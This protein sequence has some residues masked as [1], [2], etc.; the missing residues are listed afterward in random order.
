MSKLKLVRKD[1]NRAMKVL[2]LSCICIISSIIISTKKREI[3]ILAFSLV[4]ELNI[5]NPHF[6]STALSGTPSQKLLRT[7]T[8]LIKLPHNAFAEL[9]SPRYSGIRVIYVQ[10]PY[11]TINSINK[12]RSESLDSGYLVSPKFKKASIFDKSGKEYKGKVRLKGDLPDHWI[13]QKRYSLRVKL[14]PRNINNTFPYRSF[15]L[16]KLRSRQYPYEFLFSDVLSK[17]GLPYTQHEVVR[18]FVN[19]DDWGYMDLQEHYGD[20]LLERQKRKPSLIIQLGDERKWKY[21]ISQGS[22]PRDTNKRYWLSN[23]RLYVSLTGKNSS[24]LLPHEL[25]QLD[26]VR[27]RLRSPDYQSILFDLEKLSLGNTLFDLWG[28]HHPAVMWNHRYYLNPYTL[29]LE[30]IFQDQGEFKILGVAH[31][32]YRTSFGFFSPKTIESLRS[33][34][35]HHLNHVYQVL[36]SLIIAYKTSLFRDGESLTSKIIDG[37]HLRI[38]KR[39]LDEHSKGSYDVYTSKIYCINDSIPSISESLPA[40]PSIFAHQLPNELHLFNL[41]CSNIYLESITSCNQEYSLNRSMKGYVD[42]SK[43]LILPIP[44]SEKCSQKPIIRYRKPNYTL[45]ALSVEI[46]KSRDL[47]NPLTTTSL[48]YWVKS[49]GS[50]HII[51]KGTYYVES[52]IVLSSSLYIE[53]GTTLIF[54][55]NS[56]LIVSGDLTVGA[57]GGQQVYMRSHVSSRGWLGMYVYSDVSKPVKVNVNNLTILETKALSVGVLNLTGGFNVYNADVRMNHVTVTAS[58]AEDALNIVHSN[59][60][61]EDLNISRAYSDAFDCDY[62]TGSIHNLRLSSVGGDGL[63]LSGSKITA[64]VSSALDVKDKVISV[65][66]KTRARLYLDSINRAYTA[67]AVKDAS[68]SNI[69]L[70]NTNTYGPLVMSYAKKYIYEG[71]A[72]ANVSAS[73]GTSLSPGKYLSSYGATIT[74]NGRKV[75]P[76]KLNVR[77]LYRVGPMRKGD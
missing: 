51:K 58:Q 62:C 14:D 71:P 34:F 64:S 40:L 43:P 11:S 2:L 68:V 56:Y 18:V 4:E 8:S 19:G 30:P 76:V 13:A 66:E 49:S 10:L 48:P 35:P 37:N 59:V 7:L 50:G 46:S 29:K 55:P 41:D 42:I 61:I 26:Y 36:E 27:A 15:S 31:E 3:K 47:L 77:D 54:S 24:R 23:P 74:L 63:D 28:N 1:K 53:P 52:P 45:S 69:Y 22:I 73:M 60:L 32:L 33:K 16:H 57:R 44:L 21:Y 38:S 17:I 72:V 25:R 5:L 20:D 70:K 39:A 67:V 6:S 75:R 65:G 9:I 12:T